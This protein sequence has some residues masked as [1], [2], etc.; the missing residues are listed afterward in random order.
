MSSSNMSQYGTRTDPMT[1]C[2]FL[3]TSVEDIDLCGKAAAALGDYD[4]VIV[5][6]L[7][8]SNSWHWQ[9]RW[10]ILLQQHG[11]SVHR[12]QQ[13]D[14]MHPFYPAWK[15]GLLSAMRQ[16]HRRAI[17]IAHSLGAVLV[18]RVAAEEGLPGVA[19]AFLVAPADIEQHEGPAIARINAF[20]PL[21]GKPLPFPALIMASENDEWLS[22]FR[23]H[24][25]ATQWNA[26][27]VNAGTLG[28]IGNVANV[29]MWRAGLSALTQFADN[30][31]PGTGAC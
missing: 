21:P 11:A 4:I 20:G 13:D 2:G 18:A 6:G 22:L 9:S 10:E 23:A 15:Q 5:P 16:V 3:K 19:G 26:E 31:P 30:L 25:L 17:L 28:H 12:V 8:G 1:T 24:F 29:G 7:D 27:L 14:W